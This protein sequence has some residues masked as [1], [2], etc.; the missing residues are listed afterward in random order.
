M[1][2]SQHELRGQ[3][4]ARAMAESALFEARV[5][6]EANKAEVIARLDERIA[7]G[8]PVTPK[9][10]AGILLRMMD[11]RDPQIG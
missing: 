8:A 1:A 4:E 2:K 3:Q 6:M 7:V 10:V 5:F 9:V 11:A